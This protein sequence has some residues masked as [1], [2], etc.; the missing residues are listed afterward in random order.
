MEKKL[1]GR[2]PVKKIYWNMGVALDVIHL[3]LAII[4]FVFGG[5][6]LGFQTYV[7]ILIFVVLLQMVCLGCPLSIV[8]Y[9]LKHQYDPN[10][11]LYGSLTIWL[12]H[13]Y[14][15]RVGIAIFIACLI[16]SLVIGKILIVAAKYS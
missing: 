16:L 4:F 9:W 11:K 3:P 8:I 14:G 5:P 1:F 13:R 15:K 10:F 6:I 12:Y 2:Y 7:P